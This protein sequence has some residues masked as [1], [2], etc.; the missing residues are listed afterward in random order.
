MSEKKE[1]KNK[2]IASEN[3]CPEQDG[4]YDVP[5]FDV[6]GDQVLQAHRHSKEDE[7]RPAVPSSGH[8]PATGTDRERGRK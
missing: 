2:S 3:N 4:G 6:R 5:C 1:L 8:Q 7:D